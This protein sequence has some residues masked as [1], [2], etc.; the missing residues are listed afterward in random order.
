MVC[1]VNKRLLFILSVFWV[2]EPFCLEAAEIGPKDS[3]NQKYANVVRHIDEQWQ[4][5]S[6]YALDAVALS[7]AKSPGITPVVLVSS[8]ETGISLSNE[9]RSLSK[10]RNPTS[11]PHILYLPK[12]YIV[13][14]GRFNEVYEW[15]TYFVVL[16]LLESKRFL[17]AKDALDN[18]LYAVDHYG[19]LPTANRAYYLTRSQPPF[20]SPAIQAFY[21]HTRDIEF[22]RRALPLIE[23][24]YSYFMSEAR[25]IKQSGL[26]RYF[27]EGQGPAPEVVSGEKDKFGRTHYDRVAAHF[28]ERANRNSEGVSRFYDVNKDALTD[29][30]YLADRAMRESGFDPSERFGPFG[31]MVLDFNPVCLN[32]LLFIMERHLAQIH[33]QLGSPDKSRQWSERAELRS[34]RI[35]DLMWDETAGLYFDYDFVSAKR[36]RYPFLTTFWPMWAKMASTEQAR[37]IVANLP[38]FERA[39]GLM[40]SSCVSGNQWDAP[41]GFAPL[42]LIAVEALLNYGYKEEA[43]RIAISFLD[44][45]S[46]EFDRT[47]A[48]YEKYDVVKRTADLEDEIRFGYT[49]N[50]KGFA[51]TNGVFLKLLSLL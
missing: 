11:S 1:L 12:P 34:R 21:N 23:K 16:G 41:F 47:G 8:K 30:F 45:V 49:T 24:Y 18:A 36:R 2:F 6:R 20:L 3:L 51:W 27:D 19:T 35:N 42:Q 17:Q 44:L 10:L 33:G 25:L 37:R 14:G 43:R 22:L 50:E 40:T 39:G 7:D 31:A 29:E 5:L 9:I 4:K 38:L 15:D 26:S 13:P 28:R 46:S 48:L 32:T